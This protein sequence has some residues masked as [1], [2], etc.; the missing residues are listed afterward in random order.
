[1]KYTPGSILRS[2]LYS[3]VAMVIMAGSSIAQEGPVQI[4]F[5]T[6]ITGPF[7]EFGEGIRRGVEIAVEQWNANGGINGRPVAIG[8]ALDDQL[9]P[10]RAVQN[11]RRVLDN[12]DVH[13]II[14]PSGSGPTLAVVDMLEADGRPVCNAQ[15]QTP[16]IIYPNG[17]GTPPR[18]NVFSVAISNTVEAEKLA[19]ALSGNYTDIG[20][21]HE[22]TGYGV[23]GSEI[24]ERRLKELDGN[25]KITVETYNQR[26]P[27]MTAQLARIQRAGAEVLVVVGLG[28][29]LA[30]IRRNMARLNVT[31]PLVG[32]AGGVTPP[33]I[34]GAGDLVNGTRAASSATM[35][36][37]PYPT[38]TQKFLDLYVEKHGKDRWWGPE[39]DRA[40]IPIATTVGSGYDCANLLFTAI[41]NAG[42]TEAAAVVAEMEKITAFPGASVES[43]SFSEAKHDALTVDGLTMYEMRATD[44]GM[45]LKPLEAQK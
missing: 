6:A 7:N 41:K 38:E 16:L 14:A 27:D 22:S 32:T 34:E 13:A 35:G 45:A 42:S 43:I 33:Y 21:L 37:D 44:N 24:L 8:E 36:V 26:A 3:S 19:E 23:T 31:I 5:T 28:A 1:M 20:I 12:P 40:Q 30:V 25:A 17:A 2:T 29:D 9:V 15:A 10:D 18:K 4:G 11:M 39:E